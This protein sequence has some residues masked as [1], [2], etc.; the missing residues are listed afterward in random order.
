LLAVVAH[1]DQLLSR[2]IGRFLF[3]PGDGFGATGFFVGVIDTN[4]AKLSHSTRGRFEWPG[5]DGRW[6][7][8]FFAFFSGL[9]CGCRVCL[10]GLSLGWLGFGFCFGRRG[11]RCSGVRCG[12]RCRGRSYTTLGGRCSRCVGRWA[13]SRDGSLVID[14][15]RCRR[16]GRGRCCSIRRRR[17]GSGPVSCRFRRCICSGRCRRGG[18]RIRLA[19]A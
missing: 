4:S 8:F 16:I 3:K 9:G 12:C 14:R 10:C 17:I 6:W 2:A 1:H 13:C 18:L 11:W 7:W 19:A 5:L 15:F